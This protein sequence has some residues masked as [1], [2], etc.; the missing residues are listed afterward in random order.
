MTSEQCQPHLRMPTGLFA[1]LAAGGGSAEAMA[2]LER[3]ERT[4]R[5]LL[6]RT[7]LD[8][9]EA[10]PTPLTPA[11]DA[12]RV[13]KEASR[14]AP[15][16]VDRLLLAPATGGWMAHVLR[17]LYGTASGPALWT[18]TGHLCAL[19]VSASLLAGTEA[20]LRVVLTDG[21]LSLPGLGLARLP[22]A[23]A[24]PAVGRAVTRRGTLTLTGQ[25]PSTLTIRP[26]TAA[27]G[28]PAEG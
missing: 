4:R 2:F 15:G 6:L 11:A 14:R 26:S 1:E 12:W 18:E 20:D 21:R 17:R 27:L 23:P 25:G 8:R 24:G 5:L 28:E 7:L 10:L 13:V 22:E 19:A 3:S 9:F 16:P